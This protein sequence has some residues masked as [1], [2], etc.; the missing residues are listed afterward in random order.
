MLW[1]R[2][3][4]QH[5]ISKLQHGESLAGCCIVSSCTALLFSCCDTLLLRWLVVA[6][7]Q[8][9]AAIAIKH[10]C[11]QSLSSTN[12]AAA[13]AAATRPPPLPP[14]TTV[15]ITVIHGQ[16]KKQQQHHHQRTSGSTNVI[17]FTSLDKLDLFYLPTVSR[18]FSN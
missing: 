16:R 13:A 12:N 5:R 9:N 17:T 11:H 2:N 15:K 10:H 1:Q 8:L 6:R 7:S 14:P 3:R 18:E 4:R